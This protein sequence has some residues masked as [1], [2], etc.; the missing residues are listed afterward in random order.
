MKEQPTFELYAEYPARLY[1][2]YDIQN[3][4]HPDRILEKKI[5]YCGGAGMGLGGK[6]D[7]DWWFKTEKE[8]RAAYRK[9]ARITWLNKVKLMEE[10]PTSILL[11]GCYPSKKK[12]KK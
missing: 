3:K 2:D 8:A 4:K 6:R 11:E 10:V 12:G 5:G 1:F 7:I 9:L